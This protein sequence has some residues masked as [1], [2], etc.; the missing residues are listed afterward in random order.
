V[1]APHTRGSR[2]ILC[3][4]QCSSWASSKLPVAL[5]WR[6]EEPTPYFRQHLIH[7]AG[8]IPYNQH[9]LFKKGLGRLEVIGTTASEKLWAILR[10][11]V[12]SGSRPAPCCRQHCF[13]MNHQIFAAHNWAHSGLSFGS[14]FAGIVGPLQAHRH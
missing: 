5:L 9:C 8:P 12:A 10:S 4:R 2:P 13:G 3:Q 1:A 14:S 6:E 7:R 11:L